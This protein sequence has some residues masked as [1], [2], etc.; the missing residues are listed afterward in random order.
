MSYNPYWP[1]L[2][3]RAS[4]ETVFGTQ[5]V[6]PFFTALLWASLGT[7]S[8]ACK[9]I[10][11]TAQD[12]VVEGMVVDEDTTPKESA[13]ASVVAAG[14][15]APSCAKN[16]LGVVER[17]HKLQAAP[18]DIFGKPLL[19]QRLIC[20]RHIGPRDHGGTLMVAAR[21]L[22]EYPGRVR[23]QNGCILPPQPHHGTKKY[24]F[25]FQRN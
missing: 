8:A 13:D 6:P 12:S 17:I 4:K 16:V 1:N 9:A 15:G 2:S 21:T 14:V 18:S 24:A 3:T 7:A 22:P 5:G 20:S 10:D 11:V 19:Q 25:R 23:N